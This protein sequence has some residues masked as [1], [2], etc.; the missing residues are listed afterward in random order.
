MYMCR[1][2]N[3]VLCTG[4]YFDVGGGG[5]ENAPLPLENKKR[6]KL[7]TFLPVFFLIGMRYYCFT[8]S[9]RGGGGY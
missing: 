3:V 2:G 1:I 8:F 7:Y 9:V 4:T 5:G 6:D